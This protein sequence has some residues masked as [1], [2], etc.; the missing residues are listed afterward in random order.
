MKRCLL[1]VLPALLLI[2]ADDA[3]KSDGEALQ[4]TWSL[5]AGS[6]KNGKPLPK[7]LL[8]NLKIV[9][10]GKKIILKV[11]ED[12][13]EGTFVLN[14]RTKP[15]RITVTHSDGKT[16]NTR[17]IY[18]FD[19]ETLWLCF[20][21]PGEDRPTGFRPKEGVNWEVLALERD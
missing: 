10:A 14:E 12:T 5:K 19:K 11:G 6:K 3:P 1:F 21:N 7:E 16:R 15:K 9:F 18:Q 4:G 17:G 8:K 2:A 13:R 20:A